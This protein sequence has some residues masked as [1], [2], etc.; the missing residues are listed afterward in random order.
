MNRRS[1]A[2]DAG[3][4]FVF[5]PPASAKQVGFWMADTLIPLSV[6]FVEPNLTIEDIQ[7]MQ[8]L[9]RDIHYTQR[10]YAYAIEANLGYFANHGVS[11]GDKITIRH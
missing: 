7:D 1:L 10:D 6:A 3:M 2:P 5:T 9:S 11:A 8:A 4:L